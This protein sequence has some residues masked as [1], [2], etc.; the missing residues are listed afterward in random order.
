[1]VRT[2]VR[3][4]REGSGGDGRRMEEC[5]RRAAKFGT[6]SRRCAPTQ[7][8]DAPSPDLQGFWRGEESRHKSQCSS[9]S[10]HL[11]FGRLLAC[12]LSDE[13]FGQP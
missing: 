4:V 9:V 7:E 2:R 3:E 13:S 6:S 10:T 11:G 8:C 5:M 12:R 1:M